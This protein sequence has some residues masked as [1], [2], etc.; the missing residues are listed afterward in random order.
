[1]AGKGATASEILQHYYT[2]VSLVRAVEVPRAR[3]CQSLIV[4]R[5]VDSAGRPFPGVALALSGPAGPFHRIVSADGRFWFSGLPAGEWE[6]A[7]KGTS[8]R[9]P[10]LRT[11]GRST[12]E[13]QAVIPGLPPLEM[14]TLPVAYPK[15]LLGTLG[16]GSVPVTITDSKGSHITIESGSAPEYDP[17]GFAIPLPPAGPCSLSVLGQRFTLEIA[18][19]GVWVRFFARAATDPS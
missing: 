16:Y 2:A 14:E 18:E 19:T 10:G 13:V 12:L 17:G 3:L 15:E 7:V 6:L 11:D 8:I 9:Q 4:G 5:A 1:M